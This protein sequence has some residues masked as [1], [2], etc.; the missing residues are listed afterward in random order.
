[1]KESDADFY[2][3]E[4][5]VL[6]GRVN[7]NGTEKER[8]KPFS[9]G[10]RSSPSRFSPYTRYRALF[11][12]SY[13]HTSLFARADFILHGFLSREESVSAMLL[14]KVTSGFSQKRSVL[15]MYIRTT[16][17]ATCVSDASFI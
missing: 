1:M 16:D 9:P 5:I 15:E 4:I 13:F 7:K 14:L 6:Y 8:D 17:V 3:D 10:S 12:R 11:L 2:E